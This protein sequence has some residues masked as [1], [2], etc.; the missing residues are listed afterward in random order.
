LQPVCAPSN[1]SIEDALVLALE[2]AA[3]AGRF[4]VV[5]RI[6]DEL[7]TRREQAVSYERS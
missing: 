7:R 5:E 1:P 6:I 2:R 3:T 4:D